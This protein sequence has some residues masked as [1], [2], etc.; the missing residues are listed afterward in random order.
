VE[1]K[2][3]ILEERSAKSGSGWAVEEAG[4]SFERRENPREILEGGQRRTSP[5]FLHFWRKRGE[6][7]KTT[8]SSEEPA[9]RRP[10]LDPSGR[11]HPEEHVIVGGATGFRV[12]YTAQIKQMTLKKE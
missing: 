7:R 1:N 12:D 2:K 5:R 11:I 6:G 3:I 10:K 4:V 8:K 9:I